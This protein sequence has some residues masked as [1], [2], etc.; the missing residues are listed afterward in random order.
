MRT[1]KAASWSN[2][3]KLHRSW[4]RS[5]WSLSRYMSQRLRAPRGYRRLQKN[6]AGRINI[7]L[8]G[9]RLSVGASVHVQRLRGDGM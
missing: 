6:E 4:C 5:Q 1:A 9:A 2:A 3:H 7:E 8:G